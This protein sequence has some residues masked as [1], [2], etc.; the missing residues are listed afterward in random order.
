MRN[1]CLRAETEDV[2]ERGYLLIHEFYQHLARGD[3]ARAGETAARVVE[4][5]RR[6]TDHDLIA[7]GLS[8][9]RAV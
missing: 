9:V 7:L 5:G 6:F 8:D 4:M 1:G 3:F 2:V